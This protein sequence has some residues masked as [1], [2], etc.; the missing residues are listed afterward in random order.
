MNYAYLPPNK[1]VGWSI[2][3]SYDTSLSI[4]FYFSFH[5]F[6]TQTYVYNISL[7]PQCN[8]Q[9]QPLSHKAE[10]QINFI[11]YMRMVYHICLTFDDDNTII[12][13]YHHLLLPNTTM[14]YIDIQTLNIRKV[15][16]LHY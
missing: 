6:S 10:S 5:L 14:L 16:E 2:T 3:F 1:I 8:S 4:I 13:M 7:S 9:M 15:K 12:Y 11:H